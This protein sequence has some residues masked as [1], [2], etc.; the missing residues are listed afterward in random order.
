MGKDP[1]RLVTDV[2]SYLGASGIG[3]L[4]SSGTPGNLYIEYAPDSPK[5]TTVVFHT[6][7]PSFPGNPMR[8]PS[9]SVHHRNTHVSS[10]LALITSVYSLLD[11][12]W[13]VLPR[14]LGRIGA[15][16]EPGGYFVDSNGLFIFPLSFRL[17]TTDQR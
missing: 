5:V 10:G 2:A 11:N 4:S 13:N 17:A 6:G 12:K 8:F 7:G 1:N 3:S 16:Q 14:V 9:F 15:D